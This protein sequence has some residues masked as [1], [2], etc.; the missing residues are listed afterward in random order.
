MPG[1]LCNK[2]FK[3]GTISRLLMNHRPLQVSSYVTRWVP[4]DVAYISRPLTPTRALHRCTRLLATNLEVSF[5]D[6]YK[7]V[8]NHKSDAI[9]GDT[10]RNNRAAPHQQIPSH[11]VSGGFSTLRKTS[12]KRTDKLVESGGPGR[13]EDGKQGAG[14]PCALRYF[15][16]IA[17]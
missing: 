1:I 10:I 12:S 15:R 2:P 6:I 4:L 17:A 3:M 8:S 13:C 16:C 14:V 7:Q 5:R 9:M 11:Q